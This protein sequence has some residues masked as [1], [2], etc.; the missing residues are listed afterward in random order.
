MLTIRM[1]GKPVTGI[2]VTVISCIVAI[3]GLVHSHA[4]PEANR[5]VFGLSRLG[6]ALIV[7][8]AMGGVVGVIKAVSDAKEAIAD[9][10]WRENTTKMLQ[11]VYVQLTGLQVP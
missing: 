5:G 1:G 11:V 7:L 10:E 6:V 3:V 4:A 9:K 8:S 2:I